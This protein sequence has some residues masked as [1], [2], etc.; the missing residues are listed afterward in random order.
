M[1][2]LLNGNSP[3]I[4]SGVVML[5]KGA[6][7]HRAIWAK[8]HGLDLSSIP[9]L[10]RV[11]GEKLDC[12][13]SSLVPKPSKH[14]PPNL[15][16]VPDE[17]MRSLVTEYGFVQYPLLIPARSVAEARKVGIRRSPDKHVRKCRVCQKQITTKEDFHAR[18]DLRACRL[19][20]ATRRA[21]GGRSS[22]MQVCGTGMIG[23]V[24]PTDSGSARCT[25]GTKSV[26]SSPESV[27]SSEAQR[28]AYL[29]H[30]RAVRFDPI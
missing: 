13:I 18:A 2:C 30:K 5:E 26:G 28:R 22:P 11:N 24:A 21:Q 29:C 19:G 1:R 6:A 4:Q 3:F 12:R 20:I 23:P 10:V 14:S 9:P 27:V 15:I 7:L 16:F 8:H 17:E 25:H